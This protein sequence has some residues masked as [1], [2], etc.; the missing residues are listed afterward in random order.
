MKTFKHSGD[1][2]DLIYSLPAVK[3]LGGGV[4]YIN[5]TAGFT[6]LRERQYNLIRPLLLKQPYISDVQIWNKEPIDYDLD[7][8]R[9]S[10]YDLNTLNLAK[11][12]LRAFNLDENLAN[13]KWL[14]CKPVHISPVIFARSMRYRKKY[15]EKELEGY[16]VAFPKSAFIGLPE[17]HKD[18]IER[19]GRID[20]IEIVDYLDMAK[21]INGAELFI[22]NQSL[23]F[24]ISEGLHK[25]NI[26][27]ISDSHKNCNFEREGHNFIKQVDDY[28]NSGSK[29]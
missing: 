7:K 26:L 23:P 4:F 24:A 20:F 19:I 29:I 22:G 27:E 25:D 10:G 17:E 21:I 14:E 9:F 6:R 11:A 2:G 1:C 16:L 8:F 13:E 3:A 28:L 15:Y 5:I 12:H 18:F